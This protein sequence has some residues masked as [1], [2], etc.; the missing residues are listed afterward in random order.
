MSRKNEVKY[1]LDFKINILSNFLKENDDVSMVMYC[2]KINFPPGSI[3]AIIKSIKRVDKI[4][5]KN[6]KE[7]MARCKDLKANKRILQKEKLDYSDLI[8]KRVARTFLIDWFLKNNGD[9][10]YPDLSIKELINIA[11]RK[12]V[13]V[14]RDR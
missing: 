5:Y 4:L 12:G 7:K 3:Y 8:G 6:V 9:R 1:N 2:N 13:I 11:E 14:I 10:L